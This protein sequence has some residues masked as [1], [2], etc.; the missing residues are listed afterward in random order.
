MLWP[1]LQA[2]RATRQRGELSRIS[3]GELDFSLPQAA[4]GRERRPDQRARLTPP[5]L[6]AYR[7]LYVYKL[8]AAD[9]G[10][11]RPSRVGIEE[12]GHGDQ[13]LHFR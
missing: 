11:P 13:A 12:Q 2:D 7:D 8:N 6:P 5:P 4:R 1:T 9:V 10:D 3:G